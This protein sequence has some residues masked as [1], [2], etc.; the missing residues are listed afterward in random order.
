M[1]S[2]DESLV[3]RYIGYSDANVHLL[4]IGNTV[5]HLLHDRKGNGVIQLSTL[6]KVGAVLSSGHWCCH[7]V[8]AGGAFVIR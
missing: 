5:K 4:I 7:C 1:I 8:T 6:L 2:P 3:S